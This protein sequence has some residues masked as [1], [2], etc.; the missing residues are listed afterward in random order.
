LLAFAHWVFDVPVRG[1]LLLIVALSTLGSLVFAGMGLLVGSRAQNTQTVAGL[2]NLVSLPM[3]ICSGVFF[4]SAR[5]P[6]M[7]QPLI[8]ALPLTA[9]I[10]GVR[11]VMLDGAGPE[12]ILRQ[13]I[14]LAAWG[15]VSFGTALKLFRWQ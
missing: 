4:S 2:V 12:A 14:I 9:L 13:V 6:D 7:V 15:A 1:S 3:A 8:H 11:T 5:F 10:E